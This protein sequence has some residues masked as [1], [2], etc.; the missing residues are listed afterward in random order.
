[1]P[2]YRIAARSIETRKAESKDAESEY[3]SDDETVYIAKQT[4]GVGSYAK[5]RLL[6]AANGKKRVVLEPVV[7]AS[8]SYSY[9]SNEAKRK[10][11]F[12]LGRYQHVRSYM[13]HVADPLNLE[14]R[15]SYRLVLPHLPGMTYR[16]YVDTFG[17][18]TQITKQCDIFLSCIAEL[19]KAHDAGFVCVDFSPGNIMYDTATG[20]SYLIDGGLSS[21]V[22]KTISSLFMVKTPEILSSKKKSYPYNAPECWT[23]KHQDRA[24]AQPSMDIYSL[25]FA[26]RNRIFGLQIDSSMLQLLRCCR[27]TDPRQRPTLAY[28]EQA[29]RTLKEKRIYKGYAA[30]QQIIEDDPLDLLSGV[31]R[32][33]AR[34]LS[35]S[36]TMQ[37][38]DAEGAPIDARY[39]LEARSVS[40][41]ALL[42]ELSGC[43]LLT[44][45]KQNTVE[46]LSLPW[47]Y[48]LSLQEDILGIIYSS[49][50]FNMDTQN[51]EVRGVEEIYRQYWQIDAAA[52]THAVLTLLNMHPEYL[53]WVESLCR[54]GPIEIDLWPMLIKNEAVQTFQL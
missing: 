11:N 13:F 28:L 36:E 22:G 49:T 37:V 44:A 2:S 46:S 31:I 8:D 20:N 4:I 39:W 32:H 30:Y 51:G 24:I 16:Q 53:S 9:S 3:E 5:A 17:R 26:L 42:M 23:L 18:V 47:C 43:M 21:K 54:E 15:F 10:L 7:E 19:K 34:H 29:V 50:E 27:Y 1:M 12:F 35:L 48:Q 6:I 41:Q 40:E 25:A 45:L 38:D 14:D 52:C 33:I